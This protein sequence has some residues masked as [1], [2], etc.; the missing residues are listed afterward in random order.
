VVGVPPV[1]A[2]TNLELQKNA[3]QIIGDFG[4]RYCEDPP[5]IGKGEN[6]ELSGA[7][8]AELSGLL[9]KLADLGFEGAAKYQRAEYQGLL[10]TDLIE[11]FKSSLQCRLQI[12]SDLSSTLLVSSESSAPKPDLRSRSIDIIEAA[13]FSASAAKAA[14]S[15][16]MIINGGSMPKS[17]SAA[18]ITESDQ[19][20]VKNGS[21]YITPTAR[22]ISGSIVFEPEYDENVGVNWFCE[23]KLEPRI[24]LSD[25]CEPLW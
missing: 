16:Y 7:A 14:I 1:Y 24:Y 8:E 13:M 21:I 9:E 5:L 2:Q 20:Q 23:S 18:G 15:E 11:A 10:R 3:L 12:W 17:A 4:E 19:F 22:D 25:E 6:L